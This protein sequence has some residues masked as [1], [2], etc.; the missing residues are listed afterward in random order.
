MGEWRAPALVRE[1]RDVS[2]LAA[3]EM[4]SVL[5]SRTRHPRPPTMVSNRAP[6]AYRRFAVK[7]D[8]GVPAHAADGDRRGAYL[9]SY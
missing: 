8:R 1:L 9:P 7:A 2:A 4:A 3:V 6:A 5:D